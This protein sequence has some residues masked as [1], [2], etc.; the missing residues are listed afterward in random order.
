MKSQFKFPYNGNAFMVDVHF[1]SEELY[2]EYKNKL[3]NYK[4]PILI[5]AEW[6]FNHAE[7]TCGKQ[8]VSLKTN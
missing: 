6:N 3:Y 2:K 8:I 5:Y 1:D 4:Q 7:V